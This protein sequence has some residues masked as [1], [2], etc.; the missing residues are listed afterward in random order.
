MIN[1]WEEF[2]AYIRD[3]NTWL[4]W[5]HTISSGEPFA[6]STKL[7][8]AMLLNPGVFGEPSSFCTLPDGDE[9]NFY[10]LMRILS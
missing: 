3:R 9:V 4:G 8:G 1:E 5:G 10:Q 7:C 6:E 2:C